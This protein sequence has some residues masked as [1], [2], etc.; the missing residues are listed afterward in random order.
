MSHRRGF[1]TLCAATLALAAC[2]GGAVAPSP[3]SATA[4]VGE[5]KIALDTA[6]L[7]AGEETLSIKNAGTITHEFVVVRTDL[8]AEALPI[9]ADGGVDEE[10]TDVAH[11][12]E[13]EDILAGSTGSLTVSLPAGKYV[14]FC[15]LPGHYKG[16]MHAAIEVTAGA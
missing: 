13:V 4:T 12:D 8:A 5:F 11:I 14:V 1:A 3:H 15:N 6:K 16:G 10:A 9:G 2:G 7:A